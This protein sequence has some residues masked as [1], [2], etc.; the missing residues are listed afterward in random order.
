MRGHDPAHSL[1]AAP[2]FFGEMPMSQNPRLHQGEY[3]LLIWGHALGRYEDP[4]ARV[5][6]FRDHSAAFAAART[7]AD[8]R[9]LGDPCR[10]PAQ[11]SRSE[12]GVL[13]P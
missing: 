2:A 5:R 1:G 4:V 8:A 6:E 9:V 11:P 12:K 3:E 13:P 10:S 7:D